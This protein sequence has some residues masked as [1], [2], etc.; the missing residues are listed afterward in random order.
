MDCKELLNKCLFATI[1]VAPNLYAIEL[2]HQIKTELAETHFEDE[3]RTQHGA[4]TIRFAKKDPKCRDNCRKSLTFNEKRSLTFSESA[5]LFTS[6]RYADQSFAIIKETIKD[7]YHDR[8]YFVSS[9]SLNKTSSYRVPFSL[10]SGLSMGISHEGTLICLTNSQVEMY[11]KPNG[12]DEDPLGGNI[13]SFKLPVEANIGKI[14]NNLAKNTAIAFI[15][16]KQQKLFYIELNNLILQNGNVDAWST[17]PTLIHERSDY[18]DVLA[19]YPKDNQHGVVAAYEYVNVLNKNTTIY[20]FDGK[21]SNRRIITNNINGNFGFKP[22]IFVYSDNKSLFT[23]K[24]SEDNRYYSYLLTDEE[25]KA[26]EDFYSE[27]NEHTKFEFLTGYSITYNKWFM[28]QYAGD[29]IKTEYDIDAS[30]LYSLYIQGRVGDTQLTLKYLT[31]EIND[32]SSESVSYLTGL[33]DFNG[34]FEGADTL[35]LKTDWTQ[36]NGSA[37]YRSDY[38]QVDNQGKISSDFESEYKNFEVLVLSEMGN[39]I[40]VSYSSYS[41]PSALALSESD[42]NSSIVGWA[43]DDQYKQRT[44]MLKIGSD[45]AAYGARYEVNYNRPY[46]RPTLSVGIVDRQFSNEAL[47]QATANTEIK[48]VIGNL[49]WMSS[50]GV[51]TGY[52]HQRRWEEYKGIGYS[53]QMGIRS[54][55]HYQSESYETTEEEELYINMVRLDFNVGPY[56]QLNAIF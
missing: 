23:A 14:N 31:D 26:E 32:G 24:S 9:L 37:T 5:T 12:I 27:Y 21:S 20:D 50:L 7:S 28:S 30:L 22:E 55:L 3:F 4:A 41:L 43:F 36:L 11:P 51:D 47:Q 48:D 17:H 16:T 29:D 45:E 35:R 40:G 44:L 18:R 52:I 49:S 53:F 46:F 34:F 2:T 8:Y 54:E 38:Y 42:E 25:L 39:Y 15:N 56:A 19:V 10:C 33:I 1:F 6:A 13:R